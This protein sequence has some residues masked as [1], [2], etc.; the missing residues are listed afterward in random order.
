MAN[1]RRALSQVSVTANK[2][3]MDNAEDMSL[4]ALTR[5]VRKR[6]ESWVLNPKI[7]RDMT[8]EEC[9]P[10]MM[11]GRKNQLFAYIRYQCENLTKLNNMR[12]G[13]GDED[14]IERDNLVARIMTLYAMMNLMVLGRNVYTVLLDCSMEMCRGT[15]DQFIENESG[16]IVDIGINIYCNDDYEYLPFDYILYG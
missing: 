7:S 4:R 9:M 1:E 11:K 3:Y 5:I 14:I 16:T 2:F 10:P 15:V 8:W 12:G 13:D 6:K